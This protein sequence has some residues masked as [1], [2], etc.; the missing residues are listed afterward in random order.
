VTSSDATATSVYK[1]GAQPEQVDTLLVVESDATTEAA[2]RRDLWKTPR[3]VY[4]ARYRAHL[5]LTELGDAIT[6][7]HARFG[8]SGGVTG[9]VTHIA[10][11]WL[12]GRVTIGVL[13]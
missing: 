6:L 3:Q 11:D 4:T 8:L 2:R 9:L 5:L 1:L 12:A 10:R 13:A 7:T